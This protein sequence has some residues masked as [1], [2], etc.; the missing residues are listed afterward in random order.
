MSMID[1][2]EVAPLLDEQ[3]PKLVWDIYELLSISDEKEYRRFIRKNDS[4]SKPPHVVTLTSDLLHSF[5]TKRD[6][7]RLWRPTVRMLDDVR[8]AHMDVIA[9]FKRVGTPVSDD[10]AIGILN[11]DLVDVAKQ[12]TLMMEQPIKARHLRYDV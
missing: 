1:F 7:K 9:L 2:N 10:D 3:E 12:L 5:A 8:K 6:E 11:D 4:R